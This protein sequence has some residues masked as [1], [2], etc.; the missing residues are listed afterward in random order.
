MS[1]NKKRPF[2]DPMAEREAAQYD[3]PVPSREAVLQLLAKRGTPLSFDD[4]A[5]ALD[6]TGARDQDAF[7]RRLGAMERD[8]Q[9]LK[10]RRECYAL[11]SNM[12]ML[13]GRSQAHP[14]PLHF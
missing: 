2:S 10:N 12:D 13:R 6:V 4:I 3:F 5:A 8:G 11:P 7:V 14:P 9:I 1:T